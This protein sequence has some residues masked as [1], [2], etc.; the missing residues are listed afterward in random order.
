MQIMIA[1]IL[2]REE[3]EEARRVLAHADFVDGRATA[4]WSAG[5][6]KNNEQARVSAEIERLQDMIT[7]RVRANPVFALAVRPKAIADLLLSRYRIGNSYGTHIDSPVINGLRT[8]VSFTLS[9]SDPDA[10]EGG[11]LMIATP[12]GEDAVKLPAG[13]L[14]AYPS[15]TLHRVAEVTAG[16]RLAAVG[17]ARSFI[18]HPAQRELLFDLDTAKRK[19][20]DEHGKTPE[21]DL[22]SKCGANL[23]RMWSED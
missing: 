14:F 11:E 1:D 5:L 2:S 9:L 16:E 18:R 21:F 19:L 6:V 12:A 23:L 17:W 3:V 15:T 22:L 10:Y 20:F 13:S 4:G 7:D 8:D